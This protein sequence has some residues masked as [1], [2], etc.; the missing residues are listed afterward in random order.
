MIQVIN[1]ITN[2]NS[3]KPHVFIHLKQRRVLCD[4]DILIYIS[5]INDIHL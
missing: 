1:I 2:L 4:Y 3:I 5:T